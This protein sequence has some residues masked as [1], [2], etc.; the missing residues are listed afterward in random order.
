MAPD[1][2]PDNPSGKI[3]CDFPIPV[4]PELVEGLVLTRL[5]VRQGSPEQSRRAHH[6]RPNGL[7]GLNM[8]CKLLKCV[9]R[10][11]P[12]L[13][14]TLPSA[15][16]AE[17]LRDPTRPPAE[18]NAASSVVPLTA[19]PVKTGLQSIIISP[20]RRAAIINGQTI[21]LGGK[22]GN[23]KLIEVNERG[24]V[25][26]GEQGKQTLA[27][28][29]SVNLKLKAE[30]SPVKPLPHAQSPHAQSPLTPS[31]P[32]K[33][34]RPAEKKA[35]PKQKPKQNNLEKQK[36]TIQPQD[37]LDNKALNPATPEEAK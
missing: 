35:Q 28:F 14:L 17:A 19:P 21:E 6:E 3:R 37:N 27:L 15:V 18:I 29:P 13:L 36:Q 12:L 22:Y 10:A 5:V 34:D 24:V 11:L 4:R 30:P 9:Q 2:N 8:G 33:T 7:F 23:A 31:F 1:L 16:G 32:T 26:M 20:Q 25:L